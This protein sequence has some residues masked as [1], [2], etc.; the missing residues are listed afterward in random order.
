M[1]VDFD[2]FDNPGE[3]PEDLLE[4]KSPEKSN[5]NG[6]DGHGKSKTTATGKVKKSKSKPQDIRY[7]SSDSVHSSDDSYERENSRPKKT[8]EAKLPKMKPFDHDPSDH[9][10]YSDSGRRAPTPDEA[11]SARGRPHRYSQSSSGSDKDN[12]KSQDKNAWSEGT[13]S[14]QTI[15]K[16]KPKG[17]HMGKSKNDK[18]RKRVESFSSDG[19]YHTM[20]DSYTDTD[21]AT[22]SDVTDVS[23]LN[24]PQT[25]YLGSKHRVEFKE[26]ISEM[27]RLSKP[28]VSPNKSSRSRPHSASSAGSKP[29]SSRVE[30]LL[31]ANQDSVDMKLLLQ[32][33]MEMEQERGYDARSRTSSSR[34]KTKIFKPLGP[35]PQPKK[36][37]SFSNDSVRT[38]DLEN[39]RLMQNILKCAKEAKKA[40]AKGKSTKTQSAHQRPVPTTAAIN[41]HKEQLRIEAENQVGF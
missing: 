8:I 21:S 5:R 41:R 11:S 18:G 32:A 7:S 24:S 22:D 19:S 26:D 15:S 9:S 28:P 38:I 6:L 27:A 10:D 39:Q 35:A 13:E 33:V 3:S 25:P 36:N 17:S 34:S 16:L 4:V 12:K 23:P 40:K 1:D 29:P 30:Q 2:F 31:N 14:K 20:S 37:Y